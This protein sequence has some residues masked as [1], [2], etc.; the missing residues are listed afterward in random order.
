M[1]TLRTHRIATKVGTLHVEDRGPLP[2]ASHGDQHRAATV[3]CWPSLFADARTF[4]DLAQEL[5]VDHR[6]V[7]VDG[8]GHGESGAPPAPFSLADCADAAMEIC[9]HLAIDR[10]TWVGTAWGGHVGVAAALRH[11][12][13]LDGLVVMNAPM[14]PW[15]GGDLALMRLSQVTLA[16]FGPRSFVA[17]MIAD[18][19][20]AAT[21]GP[22]RAALVALVEAALR[23]CDRRAL[24][25]SMASAMFGREDLRPRLGDVRVPTVF[26]A[27][28]DDTLFPLDEARAQASDIPG[29]RFVAVERSGHH[30]LLER[31]DV[32]LPAVRMLLSGTAA[33]RAPQVTSAS[34]TPA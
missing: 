27:G 33:A 10:A 19:S 34:S 17:H 16:V 25:V 18:K 32:V 22:D 13:R 8:P 26:V 11:A 29:C 6:V 20:I 30:S 4:D 12:E 21:A 7:V 31:P 2:S 5:G 14:A 15:R 1:T 28:T 23:R 9:D 24:R 3:L